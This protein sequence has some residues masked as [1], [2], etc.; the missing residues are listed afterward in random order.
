M[1]MPQEFAYTP[2]ARRPRFGAKPF[3]CHVPGCKKS[4]Y[5]KHHMKRH[6]RINHPDHVKQRQF[7]M[8]SESLSPPVYSSLTSC[9]GPVFPGE[10]F[11]QDTV[12]SD[13]DDNPDNN[14]PSVKTKDSE[15]ENS[16]TTKEIPEEVRSINSE[17][18]EGS[19]NCKDTIKMEQDLSDQKTRENTISDQEEEA[20]T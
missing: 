1:K 3:P 4:F 18:K 5:Y 6:I 10:S 16:N 12:D 2:P 17:E 7:P 20:M 15:S 13:K 8:L 11:L 14:E 9:E 19:N